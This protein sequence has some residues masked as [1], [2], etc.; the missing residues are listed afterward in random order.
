MGMFGREADPA[1]RCST[2]CKGTS[3]LLLN[4]LRKALI[5]GLFASLLT[6]IGCDPQNI[7]QLEE[8]VSTEAQVRAAFGEPERVWDGAETGQPGVR[9]FEYNRQPQGHKNYMVAMGS[10]GKMAALR[11]VLTPENFGKV[12]PG[13]AVQD[14]RRMLGKPMKVTSYELKGH[15]HYDWRWLDGVSASDS[16]IFTVV[17]DTATHRVLS[18]GSVRDPA[19]DPH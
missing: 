4:L 13:M 6:L 15:T 1:L 2:H 12:L 16:K 18:S 10:D 11:Q 14:V 9:I 8:G 17:A 5:M 3:M 7:A 19:L